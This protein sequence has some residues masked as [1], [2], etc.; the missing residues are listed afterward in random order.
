MFKKILVLLLVSISFNSVS[1]DNEEIECSSDSVFSEYSCNQCFDW[2]TKSE[3][4][5]L[6]LLTDKWINSSSNS[7]IMYKEQQDFPEMINLDTDNVEW[8]QTPWKEDFW[9]YSEAFNELYSDDQDGY[10]LTAWD[11][12]EWIKSKLWYAYELERNESEENSNVG[13]LVYWL[14]INTI[15]DDWTITWDNIAH[16]ECILYKSWEPSDNTPDQPRTLPKTWPEDFLLLLL[17][18]MILGFW[19]VK[20]RT[21]S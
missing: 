19:I 20:L 10:V 18:A 21:K 1:A 6:W 8:V 9:E 15:L 16:K 11:S 14:L 5:Y 12:V 2:W 17:I 4:E 7:T 3:G 13:L